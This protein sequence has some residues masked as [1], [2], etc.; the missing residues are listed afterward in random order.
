MPGKAVRVVI[1]VPVSPTLPTEEYVVRVDVKPRVSAV[2]IDGV[3][4]TRER[5]PLTF[6]SEGGT[7]H[8]F[9]VAS[10][11]RVAD[12]GNGTR[13]VFVGWYEDGKL[14]SSEPS[15]TLVVNR[16]M[17]L[18]ARWETQYFITASTPYSSVMGEGWYSEGSF[19]VLEL[20]DREVGGPLVRYV[21]DRWEGLEPEDRVLGPGI[22][23]V[24]VDGP[25]VLRAVWRVDYSRVYALAFILFA[26]AVAAGFLVYSRRR[27]SAPAAATVAVAARTPP[28]GEGAQPPV[29]K[30]AA[31]AEA[32]LDPLRAELREYENYLRRLEGLRAEG[33]VSE[34]VYQAL[35]KE[36]EARIEELKKKLG[37][38]DT[39]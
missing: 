11:A 10:D 31:I 27:R 39:K 21:F 26:G 35:K 8:T 28:S 18:E 36:Y 4:Y 1:H 5:L 14:I 33:K 13:R 7:S 29:E 23:S 9:Q 20:Q 12:Y 34:R 17:N 6:E 3:H 22:V 25:R 24:Y 30:A 15:L 37:I 19:A 2:R 32:P 16:S 38:P